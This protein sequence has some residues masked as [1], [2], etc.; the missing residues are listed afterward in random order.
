MAFPSCF[1]FIPAR[2]ASSRFPGKPLAEIMG[3]PMFWHVWHRASR[4]RAL[5]SVHLCTDDAR[6]MEAASRLGVPCL[7][8]RTDH[9]NGSSR[10]FEAAAAL[11]VPDDAVVVN[12]QGDE[13]A[14]E[15]AML[16]ALLAPFAA[17]E[18]AASTLACP[19]DRDEA[20]LP[21]RVKV[22]RDTVGNALYFSRSPIPFERT[23]GEASP[24]LLHVGIYAYR[25]R[26]LAA[27]T[28]L[29]PSPLEVMESLEQL[30][31]LENGIPMRVAVTDHRS[32]GV[33]RPE[34][35]ERILPLMAKNT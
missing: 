9:A 25:M 7:L 1:G 34:D 30:R 20:L 26:V 32:H 21:D 4:C 6:I 18:V 12:I 22:V 11:R 29:P 33:D 5:T 14:L 17:D 13:P 10:V 31:F 15:S 24:Y 2:Y 23:A 19:M 8:T 35:I 3:K 16:D 27:Y 28:K